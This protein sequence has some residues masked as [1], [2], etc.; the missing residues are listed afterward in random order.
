MAKLISKTY[1]EALFETALDVNHVDDLF[2]EAKAVRVIFAENPKLLKLLDHPSIIK[3]EKLQTI[4]AVFEG[5]VTQEMSAFL[6]IVVDKG[7]QA[8]L[9]S[10]LSYFIDRVKEYKHIGVAFVTSATELTDIQKQQIEKKLLDTTSYETLEMNYMTDKEL[11]GGLVIRIG[12]R[13]VDSSI[14]TRINNM[15]RELM[16]IQLS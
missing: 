9:D 1:G 13:V 15:K 8:E 3:E 16:K 7:R 2:E 5:K 14:K 11:I 4:K 12:D 10:I 6:Q